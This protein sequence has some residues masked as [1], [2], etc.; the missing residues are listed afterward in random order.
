MVAGYDRHLKK[1]GEGNNQNILT[2]IIIIIIT[3][4]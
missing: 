4:Q 3:E 1:A 2:I